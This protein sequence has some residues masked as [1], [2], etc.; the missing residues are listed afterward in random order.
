MTVDDLVASRPDILRQLAGLGCPLRTGD[1]LTA[2]LNRA[3]PLLGAEE[4]DRLRLALRPVMALHYGD[5]LPTEEQTERL[6]DAHTALENTVRRRLGWLRYNVRR[7]VL[8]RWH[9]RAVRRIQ[10]K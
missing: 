6:A 8:L 4:T 9:F 1:T 10:V 3:E 7:R 5:H 2:C